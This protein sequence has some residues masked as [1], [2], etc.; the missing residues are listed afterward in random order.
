MHTSDSFLMSN[1]DYTKLPQPGVTAWGSISRLARRT[2]SWPQVDDLSITIS[3]WLGE[4]REGGGSL[5]CLAWSHCLDQ[6]GLTVPLCGDWSAPSHLSTT[7]RQ[8][9][10]RPANQ[11]FCTETWP[12]QGKNTSQSGMNVDHCPSLIYL[13]WARGLSCRIL[14]SMD[15]FVPS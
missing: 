1:R 11:T 10:T 7:T 13:L 5:V 2:P 3:L 6:A 8:T 14:V 4:R 15:T 12:L 9:M